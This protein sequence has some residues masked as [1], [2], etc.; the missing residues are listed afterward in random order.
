MA[1]GDNMIVGTQN[2]AQSSTILNVELGDEVGEYALSVLSSGRPAIG[3]RAVDTPPDHSAIEAFAEASGGVFGFSSSNTGVGGVSGTGAGVIGFSNSSFGVRGQSGNAI[4]LPPVGGGAE[5]LRCGVQG[6]SDEGTGVRGDSAHHVGVR[7]RT[8]TGDGVFGSCTNQPGGPKTTGNAI[9]GQVPRGATAKDAQTGPFAG[10]FEGDVTITGRLFVGNTQIT[11][12][13]ISVAAGV[14]KLD[15]KG[16]SVVE[17][18]KGASRLHKN[19]HYQL[20]AMGVPAPDLHVAAP[21]RGDQFK[22]AGG[23]PNAKVSWHISGEPKEA[24]GLKTTSALPEK[25]PDRKA[26]DEFKKGFEDL[27]RRA[28]EARTRAEQVARPRP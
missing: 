2:D 23:A 14:A 6:S 4:L 12:A 26:V 25:A 11:T 15:Q 13:L 9:H 5:F 10:K 21:V 18:P 27:K 19:F 8:F 3:V 28:K 7:G 1:D 20:T 17:L 16:E 22:I 24:K